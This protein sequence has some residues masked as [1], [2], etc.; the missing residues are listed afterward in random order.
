MN[1]AATE[2]SA[3]VA[4]RNRAEAETEHSWVKRCRKSRAAGALA[5]CAV[6]LISAPSFAADIAEMGDGNYRFV[7]PAMTRVYGSVS[8]DVVRRHLSCGDASLRDGSCAR[9]MLEVLNTNLAVTHGADIRKE[10][11]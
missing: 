10:N 2:W 4:E 11:P 3:R 5:L 9:L 6:A 1:S 7:T 8:R